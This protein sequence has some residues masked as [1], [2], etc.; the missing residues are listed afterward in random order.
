MLTAKLLVPLGAPL[1]LKAGETLPPAQPKPLNTCSLT[2]VSPSL[3][4]ELVKVMFCAIATREPST[5][6]PSA[7]IRRADFAMQFLRL[8]YAGILGCSRDGASNNNSWNCLEAK[9]RCGGLRT[10]IRHCAMYVLC[11]IRTHA[12]QQ[13]TTT[14][15]SHRR[16]RRTESAG[17]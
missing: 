10:Q 4:S 12:P 17:L 9:A 13:T 3:R 6:T 11:Q 7:A 2:M 16:R 1:Q 8:R 14:I 15:R 5:L